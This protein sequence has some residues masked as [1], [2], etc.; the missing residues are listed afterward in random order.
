MRQAVQH[1]GATVATGFQQ[2][3]VR[4]AGEFGQREVI[5]GGCLRAG[6]HGRAEAG[7]A[8]LAAIDRD[9][10]HAFAAR[11]V[12]A[13]DVGAVQEDAVLDGDGVQF[14]RPHGEE[15]E[16]FG[17]V[18]VGGDADAAAVAFGRHRR[19]SGGCRKRFQACG[20]TA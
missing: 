19:S 12:V 11:L 9:D 18:G 6:V 3:F 13:V 17:R 15:G 14:A 7:A 8:G 2:E 16:A 1:R 10:E 5:A 4:V 20:P